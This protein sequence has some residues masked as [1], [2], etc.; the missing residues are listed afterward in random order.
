MRQNSKDQ[1][2]EG[3]VVGTLCPIFRC[4][5]ALSRISFV[6]PP[7]ASNRCQDSDICAWIKGSWSVAPCTRHIFKYCI[8]LRCTSTI[9]RCTFIISIRHLFIHHHHRHYLILSSSSHR[10]LPKFRY[11]NSFL[12]HLLAASGVRAFIVRTRRSG[13]AP[14]S[15]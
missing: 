14:V 2:A 15:R 4:L 11:Q 6:H 12:P 10:H 13:S 1:K 7:L 9:I 5:G 8:I 3:K